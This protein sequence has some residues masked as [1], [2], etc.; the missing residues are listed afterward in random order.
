MAEYE[1]AIEI[2]NLSKKYDEY[3]LNKVSFAVPRGSVMGYIGQNGAGK[4]TTI[5]SMMNLIPID[6]GE[7]EILGMDYRK[8]EMDIKKRIA[9][10][11][12]ELP[13]QDI[14][15][16]KD[17]SYIFEG[18]YEEWDKVTFKEYLDRFEI[19]ERRKVGKLSK[20]MKMKL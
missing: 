9:V 16:A 17:L 10:V 20:G 5:R 12:D 18:L 1:N 2:N 19:P 8:C 4:T 3:V 15:D 11:F 14:F 13:V 6:E 7:I